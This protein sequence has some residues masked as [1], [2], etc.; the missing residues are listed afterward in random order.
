MTTYLD[1]EEINSEE[2]WNQMDLRDVFKLNTEITSLYTCSTFGREGH[3]G[4][5]DVGQQQHRIHKTHK[6]NRLSNKA[7]HVQRSRSCAA[8]VLAAG[9]LQGSRVLHNSVALPKAF[10]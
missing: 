8:R 9:D 6:H 5:R 3:T 7:G 1:V 2:K 4:M 10:A